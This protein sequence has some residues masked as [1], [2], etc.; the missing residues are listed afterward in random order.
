MCAA[1]SAGGDAGEG[2]GDS[3]HMWSMTAVIETSAA[4]T[5]REGQWLAQ[6]RR[7]KAFIKE[8]GRRPSVRSADLDE[9]VPALWFRDQVVRHRRGL[10]TQDRR[11]AFN[12]HLPG[13]DVPLQGGQWLAQ[14]VRYKAFFTEHGRR[15]TVRPG[16][17][18]ERAPALWFRHQGVLARR[19]LLKPERRA[20][21]NE[22]LPGWD[23]PPRVNEAKAAERVK[24]LKTYRDAYGKWP[25]K[26]ST[27]RAVVELAQWHSYEKQGLGTASTRALLDGQVPGWNETVQETW[28][29]TAQ[30][31]ATFRARYG[32]LPSA[33]SRVAHV[34]AW[35][36]WISDMRT[37]RG[38]T[39]ERTAHLDGVL[40]GWRAGFGHGNRPAQLSA[41]L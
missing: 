6:L 13:W 24:A 1:D 22:N 28:E 21:L 33:S 30:E 3:A 11:A 15:P 37:G 29:R 41:Q 19:G 9:R 26:R 16:A 27:D 4:P 2:T 34:R 32:E 12:E 17:P 18:E 23:V 31:I 7:Y 5:S 25:S 8:H 39:P 36:R 38:M 14:L 10:L 20:A 40:P 35:G